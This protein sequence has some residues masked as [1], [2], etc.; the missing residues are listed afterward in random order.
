M[1]GADCGYILVESGYID[2]PAAEVEVWMGVD[3]SADALWCFDA[4]LVFFPVS[5]ITRT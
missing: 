3:G 2:S 1:I 4:F 5:S